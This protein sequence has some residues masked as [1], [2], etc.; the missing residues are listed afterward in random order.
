MS[1]AIC[2]NGMCPWIPCEDYPD[3]EHMKAFHVEM[4]KQKAFDE[5][6]WWFQ[7]RRKGRGKS[8]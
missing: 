2:G 7:S 4:E 1:G 6:R 8:L 5:A 3:C